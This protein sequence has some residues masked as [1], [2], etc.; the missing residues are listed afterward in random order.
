MP[1]TKRP[2]SIEALEWVFR[3]SPDPLSLEQ[4][5]RYF[6]ISS[7]RAK[8]DL[9][10]LLQTNKIKKNAKNRLVSTDPLSEI[11][12]CR[13]KRRRNAA[14]QSKKLYNLEILSKGRAFPL[15]VDIPVHIKHNILHK[16][17]QDIQPGDRIAVKL[18]RHGIG[19]RASR[20]FGVYPHRTL[21][22]RATSLFR[23]LT[24]QKPIARALP[25]LSVAFRQAANSDNSSVEPKLSVGGRI[26]TLFNATGLL[27]KKIEESNVYSA[28]VPATLD[29][30]NPELELL[31]DKHHP[32]S[33]EKIQKIITSKHNISTKHC[34]KAKA[35]IEE[36]IRQFYPMADPDRR[37]L[38][39]EPIVIVDPDNAHDHDDG[40]LIQ[41]MSDGTFRTL[42]VISDVAALVHPGTYLDKNA[43]EKGFTY[44]FPDGENAFPMFPK[45]LVRKFSL[46]TGKLR[47]VLY[48]EAFYDEKGDLIDEQIGKGVIENQFT[49]DYETFEDW[50]R[51]DG[52][53]PPSHADKKLERLTHWA[54]FN[55]VDPNTYREF[56]DV[57]LDKQRFEQGLT[58]D[59]QIDTIKSHTSR[60]LVEFFMIEK[61]IATA[62]FLHKEGMIFPYRI[63]AA[64]DNEH[65][66]QAYKEQLEKYGY[67]VPALPQD[68]THEKI[69]N[70]LNEAEQRGERPKIERLTLK[71]IMGLGQYSLENRGHFSLGAE[72]YAQSTSPIR[73]Y[74]DLMVQRAVHE[75][76]GSDPALYYAQAQKANLAPIVQNMNTIQARHNRALREHKTIMGFNGLHHLLDR[77]N[78]C[79]KMR[80]L[81]ISDEG[82]E[83]CWDTQNG[84]KKWIPKEAL[85]KGWKINSSGNTLTH[86]NQVVLTQGAYVQVTIGEIFPLDY[87]YSIHNM[88]PSPKQPKSH[89]ILSRRMKYGG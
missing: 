8:Q 9:Q 11:V 4:I 52:R 27:P 79:V 55:D 19:L 71:H 87:D 82:I 77:G 60:S 43:Q 40:I 14:E 76:L 62:E 69:S 85:P 30:E 2:Y 25:I 58:F 29:L 44:Y 39:G 20:I 38:R 50:T 59:A 86:K 74:N 51:T 41:K 1:Q 88:T 70:I 26:T 36:V 64:V 57:I 42:T 54:A 67:D 16:R 35:E 66:Y 78:S 47:P 32:I 15:L 18:Q 83:I 56:C 61:G 22:G 72:R 46:R 6:D 63:H 21:V 37:D 75:A 7:T 3:L 13:I 73:R 5:E 84:L 65:V 31:S 68:L 49:T 81:D 24:S 45:K 10:T 53:V 34:P 33:G 80:I 48:R 23:Q 89:R 12:V 17:R 28:M